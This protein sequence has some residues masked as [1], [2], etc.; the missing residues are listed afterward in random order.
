MN[1]HLVTGEQ[2]NGLW[3]DVGTTERLKTA[4]ELAANWD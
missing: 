2:H 3:L 4:N 1:Q